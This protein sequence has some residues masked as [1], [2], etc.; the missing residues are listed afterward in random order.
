MAALAPFIEDYSIPERGA[1]YYL[2]RNG[3]CARPVDTVAALRALF[4]ENG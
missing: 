2:C 4:V 1:R 3:A